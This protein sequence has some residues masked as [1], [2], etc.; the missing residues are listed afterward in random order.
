MQRRARSDELESPR[1][2][3]MPGRPG[4]AATYDAM[5]VDESGEYDRYTVSNSDDEPYVPPYSA[6]G[7]YGAPHPPAPALPPLHASRTGAYAPYSEEDAYLDQQV[8]QPHQMPPQMPPY[9]EGEDVRGALH[10][11]EVELASV[12]AVNRALG[13]ENAQ[14]RE[15]V[16][17][18]SRQ[19]GEYAD[20]ARLRAL[21][22]DELAARL[23]SA[24]ATAEALN[25]LL[26]TCYAQLLRLQRRSDEYGALEQT[27]R[28]HGSALAY[29]EDVLLARRAPAPS[30][31]YAPAPDLG[32]C[33]PSAPD[34]YNAAVVSSR[35]AAAAVAAAAAA[36]APPHMRRATSM[37]TSSP[38][39][40]RGNPPVVPPP[41]PQYSPV[42]GRAGRWDVPPVTVPMP[43]S[44]APAAVYPPR[45]PQPRVP[46]F[47]QRPPVW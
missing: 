46:A 6:Y 14:L 42:R 10:A 28:D 22:K 29:L 25:G 35:A 44:S 2:A 34:A 1:R 19:Y 26:Q 11:C 45:I 24:A 5:G 38:M 41:Q 3:G 39:L 20:V 36:A 16:A 7:A 27:V 8:P 9:G 21:D 17:V 32:A 18:L 30:P 37:Y 31:P 33:S 4:T 23:V 40:G 15:A 13:A 47:T 43:R 12:R